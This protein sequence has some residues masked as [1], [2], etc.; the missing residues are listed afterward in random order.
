MIY[1]TLLSIIILFFLFALIISPFVRKYFGFKI[2]A[3]CAA[4]SIT[5]LILLSIKTLKIY[6]ID[7][8][9]IAILMGGSVVGI[10]YELG[11]Y[12]KKNSI[13]HFWIVR[14][15]EVTIGFYIVYSIT[16]GD[17]YMIGIGIIGILLIIVIVLMLRL[18]SRD[19]ESK[20]TKTKRKKDK[21]SKQEK[22][23]AINKLEKSLE[24]CC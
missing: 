16:I 1:I 7:N 20:S 22:L 11:R 5:W 15:L 10:M 12:F 14:V 21:I 4:S 24:D 2:C 8:T 13:K 23:D 19:K 3:I 6:E 17:A 9:I 18:L